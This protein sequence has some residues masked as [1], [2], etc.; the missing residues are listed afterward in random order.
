MK[1]VI[2]SKNNRY[3]AKTIDGQSKNVYSPYVVVAAMTF[4]D[5][6]VENVT[7]DDIK[8]VKDGK[9]EIVTTVMTPGMKQ[10]LTGIVEDK[11]L[12]NFKD[13]VSVEM[14]IKDYKPVEIYSV[15]TN[16]SLIHISEPTR[17]V[18]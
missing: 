17:Q 3:E 8:V 2:N 7:S 4:D 10:N 14:D 13:E 15:I 12:D 5:E 1:I 11:E 16:L 9:N 6:K 18:R